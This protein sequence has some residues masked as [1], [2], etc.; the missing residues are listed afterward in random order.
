V[1]FGNLSEWPDAPREYA[2]ARHLIEQVDRWGIGY[3][4]AGQLAGRIVIPYRDLYGVPHG[5]TARTFTDSPIRY[6][7]PREDEHPNRAAMF[8]EQHWLDVDTDEETVIVC[9]GALNALAVER[10]LTV[11][12]EYYPAVAAT[13]GSAL[14]PA[15]AL[16]LAQ[17]SRVVVLTDPDRAGDKMA[18]HL[19]DALVRH[20]EVIRVRLP[21]KED[22]DSIEREALREALAAFT[23]GTCINFGCQDAPF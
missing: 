16:K 4:E 5:Y 2:R 11:P 22:P 1:I 15:H 14:R 7:E 3:A 13:A 9:E 19:Q 8:G 23:F 21:Q 17:F 12:G 10:A 20:S 6:K 18:G